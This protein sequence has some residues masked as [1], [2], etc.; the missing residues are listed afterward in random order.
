MQY[1]HRALNNVAVMMLFG[2]AVFLLMWPPALP[3]QT[4][5]SLPAVPP[6]LEKVRSA[7]Q[8]YQDPVRAVHDGYFSTLSCVEYSRSGRSGEVPSYTHGGGM[9]VHFLNPSLIGPVPDPQRPQILIY[10]PEGDKLRLIAAEWLIPFSTGI[11]ERP[12]VFGQPFDGPMDGHEP[13]MPK[14]L[15]HYDLHVW[16]WKTNPAGI[17]SPTNPN[18]KCGRYGYTSVEEPPKLIPHSNP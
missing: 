18:V 15:Q 7:L 17:F 8:K 12:R 1:A 10:E 14:A 3:A 16:L 5:G 9:G 2:C 6:E 13:S 4:R 11:K